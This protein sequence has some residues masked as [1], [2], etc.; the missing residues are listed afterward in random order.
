MFDDRYIVWRRDR[1][2][3]ITDQIF[4]GGVLIAVRRELVADLRSEWYSS[5]EDL[6]VTL[7]L[8]RRRPRVSYKMHI[9]VV[10]ICDQNLGNLQAEQLTNFSINLTDIVH[11]HPADMFMVLGDFNLPN[12]NWNQEDDGQSL[13]PSNIQ[14]HV[15]V[16]VFDNFTVCNFS[17]YSSHTNVNNRLL[18]LVMS[19]NEVSVT[20]C[21]DPLVPEDPNHKALCVSADFVELHTLPARPRIKFLYNSADY[22]AINHQLSQIDWQR[23]VN[24]GTLEDAVS[25]FCDT[26]N[27]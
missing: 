27:S 3:S 22:V 12:I 17:Q 1:N 6:W 20:C 19:N 8:Q 4:G 11:G 21:T 18:D 9:C 23:Q 10:Y 25:F 5:A 26:I 13:R 14:G 16:S 24:N 2:Y 7:T 15:Q